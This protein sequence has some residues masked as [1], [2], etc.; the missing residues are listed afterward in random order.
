M[1]YSAITK[2]SL[3][4]DSKIWTGT[5]SSNALTGL[6]FQP[7]LTWIK[8]RGGTTDHHLYDAVRGVTKQIASNTNEA[9]NTKSN[10]L[11]AFGTDGFTVGS[12]AGVNGNSNTYVGWN[13]KAGNSAGSS[14]SNGSVTSTVTANTTAGFSIVKY[15]NPSSGSPFTVGHGLGVKPTM[16]MIKNITGSAQNWG[17]W[18]QRIGFGKYLQLNTQISE[19]S[20]NL[21]TATS[22]TT[23]STYHDHHTSGVN[24]ISYCFADIPG[25][26]KADYY[27]GQG[28]TNGQ[29]I[30][31]GFKPNLVMVKR[32]IGGSEDWNVWDRNRIGYN[33][34]GRDK[35]YWNLNSAEST[36]GEEIDFCA[37][38]F[39]WRT[40]N[41]GLN[42]NDVEYV[43]Y[44][45]A[46]H[47]FVAN[48]GSNGVPATAE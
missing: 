33:A 41:G 15:T 6:G 7:D 8:Q 10:G 35:V 25:Y 38:G 2:P 19:A 44:A 23:F 37:T 32:S 46:E 30:N 11:T 9:E 13:F 12:D 1:A 17:V 28:N 40:T 48:V 42:G 4:F 27:M 24:L 26:S 3:H 18:H 31:C 45:I 47:P 21:V 5:G 14:N 16:I 36:T 29:F 34:A 43:F 22:T 20:A 39:K